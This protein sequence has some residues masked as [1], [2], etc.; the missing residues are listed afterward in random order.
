M[1][2]PNWLIIDAIAPFFRDYQKKR[3]NWSKIPFDHVIQSG[4]LEEGSDAQRKLLDEFTIFIKA[5]I[6]DGYNTITLD[7]L[8]HLI[9]NPEYPPELRQRI[10]RFQKLYGQ[11]CQIATDH[12]LKILITSDVFSMHPS[13]QS[14][15]RADGFSW[16]AGQLDRFFKQWPMVTGIVFRIGETDS[17]GTSGDFISQLLIKTPN[18][19]NRFLQTVLPVF[20][21]HQRT[22]FFRT[23]TVGAYAIGDLIWHRRTFATV[24]R[25]ITSPNLVISM[26]YGESDFFRYLPLNAHFFRTTLPTIVEFQNRREYEGF[27]EYPSFTGWDYERYWRELQEA[28]NLVGASVWCQTGGWGKFRNLTYLDKESIWVQINNYVT[29]AICQGASCEEALERYA[30]EHYPNTPPHV[31]IAFFTLA[32]DVIRELLYMR[33]FASRKLFFRRLRIPPLLLPYWDRILI[34]PVIRRVF[35]HMIE[36]QQLCVTEGWNALRKL[37]LMRNLAKAHSEIPNHGLAFQYDTFHVLAVLREYIFAAPEQEPELIAQLTAMRKAYKAKWK[38]RYALKFKFAAGQKFHLIQFNWWK[39]LLLRE[40]RGYRILDSILTLRLLSLI[41][42]ILGR[43]RKRLMPKFARKQAM[44]I[45]A[46]FK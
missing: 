20:E 46:L 40:K 29:A 26:K 6:N 19:A 44:G 15:I 9:D 4:M 32:D 24:F 14:R 28:P 11:L 36:N 8:V 27:G 37:Q 10:S 41:Y 42:P 45:D 3:I 35:R 1:S 34:S 25:N 39:R 30:R 22:C 17:I 33:E 18:A 2:T 21:Q 16:I 23:W 38:P 5:V 13:I 43:L 31:L 12:D 7:D